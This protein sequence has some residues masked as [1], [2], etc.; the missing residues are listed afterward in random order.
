MGSKNRGMSWVSG[1]MN[2]E[3]GVSTSQEGGSEKLQEK[4]LGLEGEKQTMRGDLVD[5]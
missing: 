3:N 5:S 4:S 2:K 1:G